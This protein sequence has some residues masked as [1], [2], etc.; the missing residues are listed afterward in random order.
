MQANFDQFNE[1]HEIG[2]ETK[3]IGGRRPVGEAN[4]RKM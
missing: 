4:V 1:W 3:Q 2:R